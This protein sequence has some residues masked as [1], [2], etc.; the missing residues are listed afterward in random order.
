[1]TQM[2]ERLSRTTIYESDYVCLYTDKVRLPSGTIIEKYHQIHEPH[3]SV[4][5]VL[6]DDADNILFIRNRRYT[7]GHL[8]WEIPAG[9]IESG[10]D[11]FSAA[12]RE[13][14]EETGCALESL[15]FLCSN[16][17]S[18]G[19]SDALIHVFAGRISS[20]SQLKDT[21]E[22][23]EKRWFSKNEYLEL[24]RTNGTRDGISILSVLYALQ[25]Y[26]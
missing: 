13:A 10:E 12:E 15:Q 23:L 8:E 17:P 21:D 9:R 7:I 26:K 6:F 11:M 22:V 14:F 19:M 24:L 1:M 4:A 3:E 25:F 16:N 5:L 18:N 20:E 2:P